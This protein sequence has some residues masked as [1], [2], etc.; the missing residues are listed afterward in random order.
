[1]PPGLLT[2]FDIHLWAEGSHFRAYEKLGAHLAEADGVA[3]TQ[4]AVWAP[5]A[6]RVAVVGDLNGW[7]PDRHPMRPVASSGIWE[8]FIP[9]VG[10]GLPA[11]RSR[12]AVRTESPGARCGRR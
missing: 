10:A 7:R 11:C 1:M 8:C 5:N 3:G 6:R 2:D 4:F 9:G 12:A